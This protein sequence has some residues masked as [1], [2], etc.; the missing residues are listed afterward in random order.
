[1]NISHRKLTS[2]LI[3]AAVLGYM[4]LALAQAWPSKPIRFVVPYT[5]GGATDVGARIVAE[6]VTRLLGQPVVVDNRPGATGA[7]GVGEVARA[8]PD[9]YTIL[10]AADLLT[11]MKLA[12][13]NITW[14]PITSFEPISQIAI[15]PLVIAGSASLGANSIAELVQLARR[16]P[17]TIAYSS[18]GLGS[19]HHLAGE[20]LS[21]QLGIKL[22]HVPYKGSSD[23]FKDLLGGQ[24]P[25]GVIGSS[26]LAPYVN[27]DRIK[28]LAVTTKEK[29]AAL[30]NTPTLNATV[31]P[32]F[33]VKTWLG[34]LAP[35]GTDPVIVKR[36]SEAIQTGLAT[37]AAKDKLAT[38]GLDVVGSSP[39]D[40][41][42]VIKRDVDRWS[43]LVKNANLKLQ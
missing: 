9:G 8:A 32:G 13:K 33:D 43:L 22:V 35:A 3:A 15:Q 27:N 42:G 30:P 37:P 25:L 4:P 36:L 38:L 10:I 40:F 21:S 23:A 14:D 20:L 16:E 39:E 34:A 29:V 5:A 17:G 41:R 24:I 6:Q 26:V 19:T 28:L 31:A 1:M 2:T 7:I 18:S 11:T 12:Q